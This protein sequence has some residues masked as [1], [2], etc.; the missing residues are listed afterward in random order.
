MVQAT[1]LFL[2]NEDSIL[3][4]MKKRG[5]GV[6]K[7]NGVGGKIEENETPSLAAIRECKEEIGVT[8]EFLADAGTLKFSFPSDGSSPM[9]TEVRVF[10]CTHWKGEPHET[11]EMRPQWFKINSIPYD[12]MWVDDQYWLPLVLD[13]KIIEGNFTFNEKEELVGHSVTE[14]HQM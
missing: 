9:N 14:I 12:E 2:R 4:A 10:T 1:L 13:N 8:P 5:F 11:E 6:N 7:W 3:L